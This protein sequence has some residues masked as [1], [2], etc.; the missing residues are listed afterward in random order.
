MQ[1]PIARRTLLKASLLGSGGAA[2]SALLPGTA[3]AGPALVHRSRPEPAYGVQSGD[4]TSHRAVV[5][6]RADR[7]AQ[8]TVEV[9]ATE[10]FRDVRRVTGP[11]LTPRSDLTGKVHL[12]GLPPG[13]QI[14]Y[15]V[16]LADPDDPRLPANRWPARSARPR[17]AAASGRASSCGPATSRGRAGA[18]TRIGGYRIFDAM[19]ELD[20]D[21]FLC[22]G[23]NIYA[24]GPIRRALT[25]PDGSVWRN[26][27]TEEKSKVA[28]TLDEFRGQLP[29]QPAGRG[30]ARVQRPGAEDRSSGTTT[31]C[32]TTGTRA[33]SSAPTRATRRDERRRPGGALP[34]GVLRV[35]PD[36]AQQRAPGGPDLPRASTARCSTCSCWTCGPTATRT[37]PTSRPRP[38][39]IL[40]REQ[41]EWLK[42]E[43]RESR[44]VWKVIAADMPLGLVVARRAEAEPRGGRTGRPGRAARP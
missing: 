18:S 28:E 39:G 17:Q 11:L 32:A 10:A 13:E 4:V 14:H 20:P 16:L 3:L 30:T 27:T 42:R 26:V 35:L 34:A 7:P 8:M 25:L 29:L 43:L 9:S 40:G 21:F 22:S 1:D 31:R 15:R 2:T 5:W 23:D 12:R 33:R 38:G 36:L 6:A 41:L 19:A 37:R 24:D 44:A